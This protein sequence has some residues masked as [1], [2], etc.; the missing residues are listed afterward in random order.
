ME[1]EI[2]LRELIET[3]WKGKLMIIGVTIVA[4]LVAGVISFFILPKKYETRAAIILDSKFMERQGLP[5]ESC[6]E[7]ILTPARGNRIYEKLDLKEKE[8]TRT[9]F[10]NTLRTEI[11]KEAGFVSITA[12]G[13]N[14]KLIQQTVNLLGQI[15]VNDF[16]QRLTYDKE[17]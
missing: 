15:S 8:L 13:K 10:Q 17:R 3:L 2:N 5:L 7:L 9:A 11:V 1:E 14:P 6:E 16:R 4:V 12:T